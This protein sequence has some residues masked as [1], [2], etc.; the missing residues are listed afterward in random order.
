MSRL[1]DFIKDLIRDKTVA[2]LGY[3]REG[4]STLR[5]F[6]EIGGFKSIA[7]CD[8][9]PVSAPDGVRVISGKDYQKCLSE[10]DI[11]MKS[12]GVVLEDGVDCSRVWSQTEIFISVYRDQIVGVTGTKGK[13]TTTTL[14]NHI[15]NSCAKNAVLLG[16]IGIPPFEGGDIDENALITLE[17]TS[18][19]HEYV[20][21]SPKTAVFLNVFPEHLDHYKSYEHYYAAK[22]NIYLSQKEGDLLIAHETVAPASSPARILSFGENADIKI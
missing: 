19:Q 12:P 2:V 17:L 7:I 15:L 20:D 13:S 21:V 4:Q 8:L 9:S 14:I 5:L 1:A 10:F 22:K 16:N 11:I 18:H 3:G 6:S